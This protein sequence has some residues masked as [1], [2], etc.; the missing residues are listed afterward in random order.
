MITKVNVEDKPQTIVIPSILMFMQLNHNISARVHRRPRYRGKAES[1]DEV[2]DRPDLVRRFAGTALVRAYQRGEPHWSRGPRQQQNATIVPFIVVDRGS[3][4]DPVHDDPPDPPAGPDPPP[5]SARGAGGK[6]LGAA[7]GGRRRAT[8]G[9][10]RKGGPKGALVTREKAPRARGRPRTPGP[11]MPLAR[12][13]PKGRNQS[14]PREAPGG[15]P[16]EGKAAASLSARTAERALSGDRHRA[17]KLRLS[18]DRPNDGPGRAKTRPRAGRTYR[19]EPLGPVEAQ[20]PSKLVL[21]HD[22]V[23][24]A[25]R[26]AG[27]VGQPVRAFV[28]AQERRARFKA[29]EPLSEVTSGNDRDACNEAIVQIR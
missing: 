19:G 22:R 18:A 16:Q 6:G 25:V 2:H 10:A 9:A 15:K 26:D 5:K 3:A 17:V 13:P 14:R 20:A 24:V 4:A 1:Q 7:R 21:V 29:V 28:A 12:K 27:V 8:C 11:G 23:G